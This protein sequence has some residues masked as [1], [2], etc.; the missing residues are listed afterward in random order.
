MKN[1]PNKAGKL[2]CEIKSFAVPGS[3]WPINV[4]A[5]HTRFQKV[6][7]FVWDTG[8]LEEMTGHPEVIGQ[9]AT[10]EEAVSRAVNYINS[11]TEEANW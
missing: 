11:H 5:I 3:D 8:I 10:E 1:N 7:W 4:A 2:A 9:Y 6:E